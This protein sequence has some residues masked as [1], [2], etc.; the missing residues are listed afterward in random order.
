MIG[1]EFLR[2]AKEKSK[3]QSN[4]KAPPTNMD[5]SME[6][7]NEYIN[8]Q[9]PITY[10]MNF[11]PVCFDVTQD[12]ERILVGG[13]YGNI[14][15]YHIPTKKMTKDIELSSVGITSVLLTMDDTLAL[16]A[17]ENRCV[18]FL[19][20]PSFYNRKVVILGGGPIIIKP[21]VLKDSVYVVNSTEKIRFFELEKL[22]ERQIQLE[23]IATYI[24]ISDDGT[25]IALALENGSIELLHGD[26]ENV[27]QTTEPNE[28]PIDI[29]TI[30]Q[31]RKF[32]A[33]GFRDFTVKI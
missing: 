3:D 12:L 25:I 8:S 1:L 26:T 18:F 32:I 30:S 13:R 21:T 28:Y 15:I 16:I 20:F 4:K 31:Y 14:G 24:D 27:L 2:S 17:T 29:L 22:E 33:A 23:A 5:E 6:R 10:E 9:L 7:I 19:D 11:I